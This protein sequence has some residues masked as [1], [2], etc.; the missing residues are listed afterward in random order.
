MHATS[1]INTINTNNTKG[2]V[3]VFEL[4]SCMLT[5]GYCSRCGADI[6]DKP[7]G[8]VLCDTCVDNH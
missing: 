1:R 8:T 6:S 2:A 3:M 7:R 5:L 4:H